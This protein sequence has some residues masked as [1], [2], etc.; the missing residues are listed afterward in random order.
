MTA[1]FYSKIAAHSPGT[2]SPTFVKHRQSSAHPHL[3][4]HAGSASFTPASA[5]ASDREHIDGFWK[6]VHMV[7]LVLV[8]VK[9]Y[10]HQQAW[11]LI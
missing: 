7:L 10:A 8:T 2:K 6:S 11:Y 5:V 4:V 1:T 9:M 3:H